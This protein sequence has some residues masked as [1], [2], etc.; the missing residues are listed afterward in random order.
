[1]IS[2]KSIASLKNFDLI[3]FGANGD[4][5]YR[6][7]FP[8]LYHRL[9]EG[10]VKPK[11]RIAAMLRNTKNN[12]EYLS[13]LTKSLRKQI[14]GIDEK[15]LA[16]LIG[17]VDVISALTINGKYADLESWLKK[18]PNNVRVYYLATPSSVFGQIAKDLQDTS[19]ITDESRIVLEKPLGKDGASSAL[20]N[21]SILKYF[22]EKQIYRIDHYLG[23]E[24]VQNLMVLR[25]ANYIF[26]NLWNANH[27]ENV[28]IT[29]AEKLG[30]EK[31]GEYYDN[32]GALLDMVQN[33]LLQLLCLIAME[34]PSVLTASQVRV[35]KLKVLNALEKFNED[36]I[37][38]HTSKGQYSRGEKNGKI[39]P[40]YL[41][42][43]GTY[44]SE[45]ETYVAI[46][47][48]I[49][50]WRWKGVPFYIRTGKRMT[51]KFSE[52]VITFKD[53]PHNIF[54]EKKLM[55]PNKL[56]I[57]LQPKEKIE[58]IQMVKVP[59]PGGYRY[60][61]LSMK[62]DYLESFTGKF[63]EAYE[64]LLMDVVRGNQTLFMSNKELKASWEWIASITENWKSSSIKN[65]LYNAGT[66]GPGDSILESN[67]N[68]HKT[69]NK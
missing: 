6:K 53:V 42:D 40:S 14:K 32:Y 4:L 45:T 47:T 63:P 20:I 38:T 2:E 51:E 16:T 61:P 30:I 68:W 29:A 66:D 8:A 48:Y 17:K 11:S 7:I 31:R 24:T 35:E 54:P 39:M 44:S 26:E 58:F 9:E 22:D 21:N 41:E 18:S 27:I 46:K 52:I 60:K 33:H 15:I 49:N 1:M 65:N 12:Q 67:H 56:I 10:Q 50:N 13:T 36:S 19:L 62:M 3:I 57:R 25:F 69:S 34:P 43:V 37:I 5:A 28:Q 23:K 55:V 64:R 59:G